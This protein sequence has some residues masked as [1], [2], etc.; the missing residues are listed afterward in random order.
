MALKGTVSAMLAA[1]G[2][3]SGAQALAAGSLPDSITMK[4]AGFIPEGVEYDTKNK[5]FLVGSIAQGKV[6]VVAPDGALTPFISDADIKS[7]VGL[8][9]DEERNRLLVAVSDRSQPAGAAKLGVYDLR[10]GKRIALVD[11]AAAGPA[12]AKEHFANDLAVGP[13]GSTYITDTRARVIY[14]VTSQNAASVFVA[15]SGAE[16]LNGIVVHPKGYLLVGESGAGD[17]YKVPLD[18]PGSFSKVTL[19]EP[20]LGVDGMLWHPDDRLIVV[21][22][23]KSQTVVSLK[24]SDDWA[25]A[26]VDSKGTSS[27]QQTT[28]A[29]ADGGVYVVHPFFNDAAAMP[30]LERVT[31]K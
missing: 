18:K 15:L 4:T 1:V 9:V 16:R 19:P 8:E 20:V 25:S 2:V 14:K 29:L 13:D 5:R 24:S 28:A 6:F 30:S 23:D 22:N 12:E 21:R 3:M 7:S 31:L 17:V 27:T 26:T 10:T 11:L